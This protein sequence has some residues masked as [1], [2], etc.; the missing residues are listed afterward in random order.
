MYA[1]NVLCAH[2]NRSLVDRPIRPSPIFDA[3][4]C[5]IKDRKKYADMYAKY[6]FFFSMSKNKYIL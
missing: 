2:L 5:I 4:Q 1:K 3:F 6:V